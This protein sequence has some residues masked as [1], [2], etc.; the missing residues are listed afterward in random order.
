M[1]RWCFSASENTKIEQENLKIESIERAT[2]ASFGS[3]EKELAQ[4]G[5]S[6]GKKTFF[7]FLTPL[8]PHAPG[9][10]AGALHPCHTAPSPDCHPHAFL[11]SAGG[12]HMSLRAFGG[13]GA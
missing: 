7:F 4:L 1:L 3:A 13:V 5:K 9:K 6:K 2:E 8:P 11:R 10:N 12:V